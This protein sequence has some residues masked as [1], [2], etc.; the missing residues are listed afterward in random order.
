[1]RNL[2]QSQYSGRESNLAP[3][4]TQ[5]YNVTA[6]PNIKTFHRLNKCKF[7]NICYAMFRTCAQ[8]RCPLAVKTPIQF[9][10]EEQN[11]NGIRKLFFL[12]FSSVGER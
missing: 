1:M 10:R 3:F 4:N 7:V 8:K 2:F 9:I 6:S 11:R 5:I 12:R